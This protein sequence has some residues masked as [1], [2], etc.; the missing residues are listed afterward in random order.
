MNELFE[1]VLVAGEDVESTWTKLRNRPGV[2]PILLGDRSAVDAVVQLVSNSSE[3]FETIKAAGLGLDVTRWIH[4]QIEADPERF[5]VEDGEL[6]EVQPTPCFTPALDIRTGRPIEQVCFGLIPVEA[7]W[8]VPAFLKFGGWND[9]PE[10]SVQLAFFRRWFDLY[11]A[12]VVSVAGDVIE[13]RV[14]RPPSTVEAARR[15]AME[16]YVYCTDIVDQGVGTLGNL[17][18]SLIDSPNWFFWWD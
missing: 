13:F 18:A 5:E 10:A 17:T 15:L 12:E 6:G 11:G 14:S 1:V 7:P 3:S 4:E 16:Q 9:C 2:V 8:L